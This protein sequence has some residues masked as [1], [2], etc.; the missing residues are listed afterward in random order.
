MINKL[1][2]FMKKVA[3][4]NKLDYT[5]AL[6]EVDSNYYLAKFDIVLIDYSQTCKL[7]VDYTDRKSVD[8]LIEWLG[9]NCEII[10]SYGKDDGN[11]R[12]YFEE[13]DGF[14]VDVAYMSNLVG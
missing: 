2:K 13:V 6:S 5:I 9:E 11:C 14:V 12:Y 1:Q 7:Y 4:L 10:E 8:N 3:K